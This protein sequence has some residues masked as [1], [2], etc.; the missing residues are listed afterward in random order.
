MCMCV[1]VYVL[2]CVIAHSFVCGYK[3]IHPILYSRGCLL[4][5]I[6]AAD[7]DD[8]YTLFTGS[9]SDTYRQRYLQTAAG[10]TRYPTGVLLRH[11]VTAT[12]RARV[13]IR[14]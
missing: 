9:D 6:L 13:S 3:A 4:G 8:D 11:Y 2:V 7:D 12:S 1:C 10:A 14:W 5:L